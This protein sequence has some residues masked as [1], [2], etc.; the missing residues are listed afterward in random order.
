MNALDRLEGTD[1]D[2][3]TTLQNGRREAPED[4]VQTKTEIEM[5]KGRFNCDENG[6]QLTRAAASR[7]LKPGACCNADVSRL[8]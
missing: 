5:K 1:M 3:R 4:L 8:T 2:T 6:Q 7:K